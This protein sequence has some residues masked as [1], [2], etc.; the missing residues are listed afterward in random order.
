V[1]DHLAKRRWEWQHAAEKERQMSIRLRKI[2]IEGF[3]SIRKL[4]SFEPGDLT[5][6]IGANGAGKSNFISLFRALSHMM[7]GEIQTHVSMTGRAH[8]WLFDGPETTSEISASLHMETEKGTNEYEF[9][10]EYGAGDTL[11]FEKERYRFLPQGCAVPDPKTSL[12]GG[13]VESKLRDLAERGSPTP[14]AIRSLLRK[15]IVHQFH[16]TSYTSRMKQAW[17]LNENRWLKEDGGNLAPFLLR[18]R[19]EQ[20]TYY[21][22]IVR[23]IRQSIPFFADF[24][25]QP[26]N[27][28][29]L[30]D[31]RETGSDRVFGAHQASDGMLRFFALVALLLQPAA[32]LPGVL[33]LDEPELGLHPHAITTIASL[34]KAA[35]ASTQIL[36]ATQSVTLLNE[37]EADHVV[38]V[39]R[40]G[41]ESTFSRKSKEELAAWL[42]EYSLGELWE[43]NILG[44]QPA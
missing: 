28:D 11:F 14:A 8:S 29:V 15:V 36:L 21:A 2:S 38:V 4:E 43:K 44:G 39:E 12:G 5:V 7:S 25:L 3:K 13:H 26:S 27:G 31:W 17:A 30:L 19:T 22:R 20:P 24:D 40:K 32:D 42:E 6:F 18:L 37:F 33:I 34:I 35:S 16:N 41:R 10:L 1:Q 23:T 9:G